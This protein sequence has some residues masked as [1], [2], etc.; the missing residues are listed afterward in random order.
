MISRTFLAALVVLSASPALAQQA[1]ER[2]IPIG[3]SPGVSGTSTLLGTLRTA[4]PASGRLTIDL[5]QGGSWAIDLTADTRLWL[6]R[7]LAR[8]SSLKAGPAE[9]KPGR[10]VEVLPAAQN[11]AQAEWVKVA[12]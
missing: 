11:P 12:D 6:D 1:A 5:A 4:D 3:Q 9:L 10:R 2:F 8:Q 7:S